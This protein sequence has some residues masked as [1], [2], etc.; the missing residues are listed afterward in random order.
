MFGGLCWTIRGNMAV[1]V[2]KESAPGIR[3]G[4]ANFRA[5]FG[6][7]V[8][9]VENAGTSWVDVSTKTTF[10]DKAGRKVGTG[11][12]SVELLPPGRTSILTTPNMQFTFDPSKAKVVTSARIAVTDAKSR[13]APTPSSN[14]T[15]SKPVLLIGSKSAVGTTIT[16]HADEGWAIAVETI[17]MRGDRI[18]AWGGTGSLRVDAGETRSAV[19]VLSAKVQPGDVAY[20]SI[21]ERTTEPWS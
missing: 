5:G 17:V 3:V 6:S 9:L 10:Q 4:T 12:K 1:G 7:T 13:P 14:G 16:N 18:V 20:V 8:A 2:A 19:M 15:L 21:H 11:V